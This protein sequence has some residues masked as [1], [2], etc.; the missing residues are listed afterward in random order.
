MKFTAE[1]LKTC[2]VVECRNGQRFMIMRGFTDRLV[3][4]SLDNDDPR[5]WLYVGLDENM[6]DIDDA[7]DWDVVK[8]YRPQNEA[9]S[10]QVDDTELR[11]W[12]VVWVRPKEVSMEEAICILEEKLGCKIKIVDTAVELL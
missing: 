4:K 2:D 12:G 6:C 11:N 1:N 8:V 5:G 7:H 9:F 10:M 3:G